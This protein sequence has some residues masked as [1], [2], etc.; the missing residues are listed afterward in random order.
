[1]RMVDVGV[2]A[3]CWYVCGTGGTCRGIGSTGM[4]GGDPYAGVAA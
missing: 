2:G 3:E 4:G 1:M